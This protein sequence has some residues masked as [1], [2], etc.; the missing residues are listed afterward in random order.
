MHYTHS[1]CS[2]IPPKGENDDYD[3]ENFWIPDVPFRQGSGPSDSAS[4]VS[5]YRETCRCDDDE[6]LQR[7]FIMIISH[8]LMIIISHRHFND[9]HEMLQR[10]F[11]D[12]DEMSLKMSVW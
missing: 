3:N 6:M 12:D 11:N 10:H 8:R 4:A 7:H 5:W 1:E 9:D 2:A